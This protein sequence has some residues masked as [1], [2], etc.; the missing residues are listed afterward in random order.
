MD[1][2]KH[3]DLDNELDIQALL[4]KYLPDEQSGDSSDD[5]I[6]DV[7]FEDLLDLSEK[8]AEFDASSGQ[9]LRSEEA[10]EPADAE[11]DAPGFDGFVMNGD[12]EEYDAY[13]EF[14]DEV[15]DGAPGE[16]N[17]DLADDDTSR[18]SAADAILG[19]GDDDLVIDQDI[20]AELM[21]S[22]DSQ[23]GGIEGFDNIEELSGFDIT[24]TDIDAEGAK[25][26]VDRAP[27]M[28]FNRDQTAEKASPAAPERDDEDVDEYEDFV[29]ETIS[30]LESEDHDETDMDFIV[31]FGLEDDLKRHVGDKKASR[32]KKNYEKIVEEREEKDRKSIRNEYKDL[33]Q[34]NEI[35]NQYKRAYF[36]SKVKLVLT[37]VFALILMVYEN[38]PV[39]GYQFASFL[40]PQV[41]PIVYV[42]ID[43]QITLFAIAAVYDRIFFGFARLFK[44]RPTSES[45]MSV[46]AVLSI[47][48]SI[49]VAK[50]TVKPAEPVLYNFPVAFG[51]FM[52]ALHAYLTVKREIFSFNVVSSKKPKYALRR[53]SSADAVMETAAFG[54]NGEDIGD[55]L[56]I[57]KVSFIDGYFYRTESSNS[58]NSSMVFM[59]LGLSLIL[60]LLFGAYSLMM[61]NGAASAILM[62]YTA[63][64]T[65]LPLSV[66]FI[67]SYPFY[68]ANSNSY[69]VNST[70]VGETSLEEYSGA[71]IITFDDK[72]VFPSVGVK[73]QNIKVYNNYRFDRVLYYAASVFTKTGGPLADVFEIA[74]VESGYSEDVLLTG[75]GDGFIQTEVDG[76]SIMFGR[77]DDLRDQGIEIPDE[78]SAEDEDDSETSVMYMIFKG[79][80]VAKMNILYSLDS[81][82]E[83]I[84]KQ[85][86]GSGMS[87]CVKTLD[88]NI[89]EDMI[90]SRVKLDKYPMRVIRYSSLEEVAY[91]AERADSGVVARGSSKGLLETVTYCDKVLETKRTASF[92]SMLQAIVSIVILA[93]VLLAGRF[94]TFRSVY[95]VLL[96]VF[97]LLPIGIITKAL[98]K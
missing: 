30:E 4:D 29:G 62:G 90:K 73:V 70:I 9:E 15:D 97:W 2:K 59:A 19:L 49:V 43:L 80:L 46:L 61:K 53:I 87:V 16:L 65:A 55:V 72:L 25:D 94:P 23:F 45:L 3:D 51:A 26:D 47:I 24:A 32:L 35:V 34:N 17:W 91:E 74:T 66:L 6:S 50:T 84:V 78:I 83:Y 7:N 11:D 64:V 12:D 69:D 40:D 18:Q 14:A 33:S 39:I 57:E 52:T 68:K 36:S 37:A 1:S 88:P 96:Q 92:V 8:D 22:N 76:K 81:D 58:S 54:G 86:A 85:L 89:D 95:S 44:G 48:Y 79:R 5:E 27:T 31:A 67:N 56:K 82:F 77:A 41:Y 21:A 63:F 71:S 20:I 60:S 42:M 75:I 10:N 93:I 28:E 13:S 98:L 38:L